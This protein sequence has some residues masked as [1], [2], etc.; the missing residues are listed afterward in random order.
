MTKHI[1]DGANKCAAIKCSHKV[2]HDILEDC[3]DECVC[4][5]SRIHHCIPVVSESMASKLAPLE[6]LI[7][8]L[9]ENIALKDEL[10]VSLGNQ[11]EEKTQR[12]ITLEKL[13]DKLMGRK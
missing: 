10:L 2:T 1:C 5:M 11:I 13:V 4:G 9:K 7:S 3:Y 8:L 6:E 12:I